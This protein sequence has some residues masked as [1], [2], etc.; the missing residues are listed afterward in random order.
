MG[1][2]VPATVIECAREPGC[3]MGM[4]VERRG[5]ELWADWDKPV[6]LVP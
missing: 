5:N 6:W 2:A 4:Y 1:Q 3:V